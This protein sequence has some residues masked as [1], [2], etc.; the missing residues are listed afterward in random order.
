M[1]TNQTNKSRLQ[2]ITSDL[3]EIHSNAESIG[4][5]LPPY[6]QK[7]FKIYDR[8]LGQSEAA[9]QYAFGKLRKV[10]QKLINLWK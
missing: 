6:K 4:Q 1:K 8:V 7:G 9:Y 5:M 2:S 3:H 10:P